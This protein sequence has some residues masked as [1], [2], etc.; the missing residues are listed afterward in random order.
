MQ[1]ML[2]SAAVECQPSTSSHQAGENMFS[3]NFFVCRFQTFYDKY[4]QNSVSLIIDIN[5][6]TSTNLH[7]VF[8][9]IG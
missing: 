3:L 4:Q 7:I 5:Q 1:R 8:L 6:Q 9:W 2:I